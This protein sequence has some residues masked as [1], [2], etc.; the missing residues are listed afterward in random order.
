MKGRIS[1]TGG[2]A[3]DDCYLRAAVT[4]RNLKSTLLLYKASP[5]GLCKDTTLRWL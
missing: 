5:W 4:A 2:K 3:E 1:I